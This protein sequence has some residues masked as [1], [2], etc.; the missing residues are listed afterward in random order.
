VKASYVSKE[1]LS[2]IVAKYVREQIFLG[3]YGPGGRVS[4]AD[5]CRELG[6][7][8]AP[9]REAIKEV[10]SQ[11]LIEVRPNKG[12][13]VTELALEDIKEI[14][15]VRLLLEGSIFEILLREDR[16]TDADLARLTEIVDQMVELVRSDD[17]EDAKMAS[18]EEMN[19]EFHSF[20]WHRSGSTRRLRILLDLQYQLRLA[21]LMDTKLGGN[22]EETAKMHYDIIEALRRKD[23]RAAKRALKQH[24]AIY[25]R[26]ARLPEGDLPASG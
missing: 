11:G 23:I 8:K 16:L 26:S 5:L 18:L 15:D 21:S 20:L 13:F 24:I 22:P 3:R 1:N 17:A 6:V 12:S 19:L 2:T 14:F 10:E 9:V 25:R 7:S 4:E